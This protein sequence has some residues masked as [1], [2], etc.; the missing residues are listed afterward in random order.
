MKEPNYTQQWQQVALTIVRDRGIH[1]ALGL[2]IGLLAHYSR[3][4]WDVKAELKRLQD[5]YPK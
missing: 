3:T 4:D 5:R 1:Y 2:L